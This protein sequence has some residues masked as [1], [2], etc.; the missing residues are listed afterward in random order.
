[1]IRKLDLPQCL[2][3]LTALGPLCAA[4][5]VSGPVAGTVVTPVPCYANSGPFAGREQFDATAEIGKGPGAFLF[6]HVLNRNTAPI[7]RGL[8]TL[9]AE[10]QIFGF[11]SF[12][13]TLVADR[14]QGEEQLLR[15]NRSLRLRNPM[16]ISLDGAEGP[17]NFALNRRCTL[18]LVLM[19]GGKV[20]ESLA[21]TDASIDDLPGIRAVIEKTI[22]D[23]PT[24]RAELMKRIKAGLPKDAD[25]LR[26]LAA[27]QALELYRAHQETSREY[28]DSRGGMTRA[29]RTGARMNRNAGMKEPERSG[30]QK[31][32]EGGA[33]RPSPSDEK[34]EGPSERVRRGKPPTD[35]TLSDLLR[36]FIRTENSDSRNDEILADIKK[37]AGENDSLQAEAI[38]MFQ[39]MLSYPDRYGTV[40]AQGLATTYLKVRGEE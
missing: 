13:I 18:S 15:V 26:E 30:S 25:A 8:D 17:G 12:I 16:V 36:T 34:R 9:T 27:R 23:I 40:H 19:N 28:A 10:Y 5:L 14:T 35:P 33:S 11:K 1:M 7:I 6:I 24:E 21:F 39:L 22:G 32:S 2:L 3:L 4:E 38:A 29:R 20:A 37:R 31:R